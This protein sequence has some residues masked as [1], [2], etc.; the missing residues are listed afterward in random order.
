ME[1]NSRLITK[2]GRLL[3]DYADKISCLIYGRNTPITVPYKLSASHDVLEIY[4]TKYL[5]SPSVSD[6]V[7]HTELV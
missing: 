5:V 4:I 6:Y 7:F 1:W 2:R 3:C